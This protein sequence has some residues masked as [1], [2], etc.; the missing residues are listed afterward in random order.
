M[1]GAKAEHIRR[2]IAYC[3]NKPAY[4]GAIWRQPMSKH[5]TAMSMIF[6]SSLLDKPGE[7][8]L[9]ATAVLPKVVTK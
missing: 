6:V 5:Y 4:L 9:E 2:M 8:E 3:R 7:I 1:A